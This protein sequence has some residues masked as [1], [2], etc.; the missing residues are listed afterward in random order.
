MDKTRGRDHMKSHGQTRGRI[1]TP[2]YRTWKAMRKRCFWP[3]GKQIKAYKGV[4][5]CARWSGV[6]GFKNFLEDM[7]ERPSGM[8]L[9]RYPNKRGNY[10]PGNCRW[11]TWSEQARNRNVKD[12]CHRGHPF[13]QENSK[14]YTRPTGAIERRCRACGRVRAA[15]DRAPRWGVKHG[16]EKVA[17]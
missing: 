1:L 8:T 16:P 4:T 3:D 17:V 15:A 10:E 12:F 9:D 7:G 14:V 6:D 2:T 13:N 11:A 5:I